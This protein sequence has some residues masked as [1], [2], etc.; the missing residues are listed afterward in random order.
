MAG[1]K[2]RNPERRRDIAPVIQLR[3]TVK[4]YRV[5]CLIVLYKG[6]ILG[7]ILDVLPPG[8]TQQRQGYWPLPFH[9]L[10]PDFLSI[11]AVCH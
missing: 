7:E 10:G 1:R 5:K 8:A 11:Q 3:V 2:R 9:R 6:G 4:R